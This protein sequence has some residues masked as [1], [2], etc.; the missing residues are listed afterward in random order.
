M[1]RSVNIFEKVEATMSWTMKPITIANRKEIEYYTALRPVATAEGQFLYHFIW[2]SYHHMRYHA[3]DDFLCMFMNSAEGIPGII[4]PFCRE[5][6]LVRVFFKIKAYFNEELNLP[7]HMFLADKLTLGILEG[8]GRFVEQ[9]AYEEDRDCF[10]YVY[11]AEK[12]R[13]LSGRK[14][15]KKKNHLN[16]FLREY[17][18][19][20]EYRELDESNMEEILSLYGEWEAQHQDE[21]R[22]HTM[23][24]ELEGIKNIV[25]NY[26]SLACKMGGIYIDG[27]LE[28]FAAGSY[29]PSVKCAYIHIEKANVR[30]HGLYAMI[31]RQFLLHA[32]PEAKYVNR[33]DD[34]GQE[35]LRRA[36][37]SWH[38]IY[39]AEK[40]YVR[41]K[42]QENLS[43]V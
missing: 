25:H 10:D 5:E 14:Y 31:N 23:C 40:Y 20:Y 36:K 34:L 22:Y 12:L 42:M 11:D 17:H 38:P 30:H 1:E 8:D 4:M 26:R 16:A 9:F 27:R 33:E 2:G 28:A 15:H 39:L 24:T 32:F 37:L 35:G 18:G 41:Q 13:T 21:D 19:R 6:D 3:E 29:A 43:V 7:L